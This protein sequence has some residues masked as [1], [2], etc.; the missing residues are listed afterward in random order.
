MVTDTRFRACVSV[1]IVDT[2]TDRM[3]EALLRQRN[4]I[5]SCVVQWRIIFAVLDKLYLTLS[6]IT[7][8]VMKLPTIVSMIYF[9]TS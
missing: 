7:Q 9:P 5:A 3:Y 8:S 1:H 4:F 2:H 6:G